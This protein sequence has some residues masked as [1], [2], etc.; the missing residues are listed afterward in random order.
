MPYLID[1]RDV[2]YGS[3]VVAI[4]NVRQRRVRSRVI[5]KDNSLYHTLTRPQTFLRY[6]NGPFLA[7]AQIGSRRRRGANRG[8]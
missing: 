5:R 6:A 1:R 2:L 7:I 3:D 4:V 8:A